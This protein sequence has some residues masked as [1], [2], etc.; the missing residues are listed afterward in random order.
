MVNAGPGRMLRAIRGSVGRQFVGEDSNYLVATLAGDGEQATRVICGTTAHLAA[1]GILPYIPT[2]SVMI[3]GTDEQD[4]YR[5]YLP[6]PRWGAN[7]SVIRTPRCMVVCC[8]DMS[9]EAAPVATTDDA[10]VFQRAFADEMDNLAGQL[11]ARGITVLL[12]RNYFGF[13]PGG[14]GLPLLGPCLCVSAVPYTN[15]HGGDPYTPVY[16]GPR[17]TTDERLT[18]GD[19]LWAFVGG[20]QYYDVGN[21]S[22]AYIKA[23][24]NS[25]PAVSLPDG[26]VAWS[27]EYR[28]SDVNPDP[29]NDVFNSV[30]QYVIFKTELQAD[31]AQLAVTAG[32]CRKFAFRF[33]TTS[34]PGVFSASPDSTFTGLLPDA[35][36]AGIIRSSG[37]GGAAT[38]LVADA[39]SFFGLD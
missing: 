26:V 23:E 32:R 22:N 19:V 34:D 9:T 16:F 15:N 39:R 4:N 17:F 1:A 20:G 13:W 12:V 7:G 21:Y 11:T 31:A 24:I 25:T 36:N 2:G 37:G 8:P 3:A 10:V 28:T 33:V 6:T 30:T 35:L 18:G 38:Q 29:P 5:V 14:R 27:D